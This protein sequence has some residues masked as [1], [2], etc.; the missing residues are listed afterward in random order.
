MRKKITALRSLTVMAALFCFCAPAHAQ[1]SN[2]NSTV[3]KPPPVQQQSGSSTQGMI[4]QYMAARGGT[5]A[6]AARET[7]FQASLAQKAALAQQMAGGMPGMGM[8]MMGMGPQQMQPYSSP[9][10]SPQ[11]QRKGPKYRYVNK[12]ATE[13]GVPP[14]LFNNIPKRRP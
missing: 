7:E 8:G 2:N 5:Q 13:V 1:Q 12:A 14:R 4:D 6:Q 10:S 11:Q 3:Y 9:Y